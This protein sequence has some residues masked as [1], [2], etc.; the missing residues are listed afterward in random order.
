MCLF[1]ADRPLPAHAL[2]GVE[3]IEAKLRSLQ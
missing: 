3:A 2:H 1:S